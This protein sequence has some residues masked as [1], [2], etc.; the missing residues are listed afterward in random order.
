MSEDSVGGR[1]EDLT[2]LTLS[3]NTHQFKGSMA[4]AIDPV[5]TG[6][7]AGLIFKNDLKH[8]DLLRFK[9]HGIERTVLH[10]CSVISVD[11]VG[12]VIL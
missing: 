8:S 4:G 10:G 7:Q 5:E 1:K 6:F 2:H 9:Q 11:L 3:P 12:V